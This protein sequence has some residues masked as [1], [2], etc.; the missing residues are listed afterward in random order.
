MEASVSET[1]LDRTILM[2]KK[3]NRPV[4]EWI[5]V[6]GAAEVDAAFIARKAGAYVSENQGDVSFISV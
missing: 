4:S 5:D 1:V 6:V 3:K 2:M